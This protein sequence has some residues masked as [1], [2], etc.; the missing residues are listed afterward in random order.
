[1]Q[2]YLENEEMA[3]SNYY[4][5]TNP[6]TRVNK[7]TEKDLLVIEYDSFTV[8]L[9][10]YCE[11]LADGKSLLIKDNDNMGL[12]AFAIGLPYSYNLNRFVEGNNALGLISV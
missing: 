2:Y 9:N 5:I 4:L 6:S 10:D 11:R 8:G 3:N 12:N 7:V 1:V